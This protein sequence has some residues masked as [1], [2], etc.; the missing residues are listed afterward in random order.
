MG[1]HSVEKRRE[2]VWGNNDSCGSGQI[3]AIDWRGMKLERW[4]GLREIEVLDWQAKVSVPC[5]IM[6]RI[7]QSRVLTVL[8]QWHHP[9]NNFSLCDL[10]ERRPVFNI[11]IPM[12]VHLVH[13]G[14]NIVQK[15]V[16]LVTLYVWAQV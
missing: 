3:P 12:G 4:I 6:S 8:G 2:D 9:T 7:F 1:G 13:Q 10:V 11:S 14:S 16:T 15:S 5:F